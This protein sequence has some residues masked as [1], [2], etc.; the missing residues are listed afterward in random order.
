MKIFITGLAGFLGSNLGIRLANRG[1]EIYGNDNLIGG[2]KDN[3][4]KRFKFYEAD[5][6]D[7]DK[8][9]NIIPKDTNVLFHCAATAYEG[10]SV[11]SP[12]FV[13]KNIYDATVSTVTASIKQKVK[14]FIFCSSMARYGDQVSPFKEEMLP[15]P[16]DPYG[17]AKAA[18]EDIVK[19]LCNTHNVDWTILVPH[20]I[21][22]PRQ[23]YNDPYRNVMS[24]F[25]NKM[26][27]N[28]QVYIYGDGSQ[29]RCFSYIDDCLDS[30]EKC[31]SLKETSKQIINIGPD[32]EV[33]T[34][35]ELAELCA[36]E[37]GH[38]KEPIF[39]AG[40]PQEVK[41]ATCS[42]DKAK[43]LLGYK[44][45]FTLKESIKKTYEYIKKN[46]AK[47]FEYHIDLEINNELTPETWKKK[48]I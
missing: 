22:G 45:N 41:F 42:S 21:V 6:C 19:N 16:E 14:K 47:K 9:T 3:I 17:F 28:E 29:K 4:D 7:L 1:H 24:I 30:M 5:C 48:L 37:V 10:L 44:T 43:K 36:N 46:G 33:I 20:N 35:R 31:I 2:Y 32:E 13:T 23:K 11:F 12:H 38:N 25:I 18:S 26:I 27:Q 40:R 39:V 8:M 15:K 34:I